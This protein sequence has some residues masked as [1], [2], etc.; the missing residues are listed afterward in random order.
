LAS[1][2][3]S[4]S[5][6]TLAPLPPADSEIGR[7]RIDFE[8]RML[9][10]LGMY[11]RADSLLAL[12]APLADD[13]R[14]V[15]Y[16]IR[17][18]TLNLMAG[19]YRQVLD[20]LAITDSISNPTFTAYL[21]Y[22]RLKA[23][24]GLER[25]PE[26]IAA[27]ERLLKIDTPVSLT[28]ESELALVEAYSMAGRP[29]DALELATD[30]SRQLNRT[31]NKI[32]LLGLRYE[33]LWQ[34]DDEDRAR[35]T[36]VK[37]AR[38]YQRSKTAQAVS[39]DVIGN[40]D[41]ARLKPDELLAH[42]AV[43]IEHGNF[44]AA[45]RLLKTL[46]QRKLNGNQ[47][48]ERLIIKARYH[49]RSGN[50]RMAAA[51]AKPRFSTPAYRR[52]SIL[53]LARSYRR[54]GKRAEAAD[55]Y[56]YF[57]ELYPNDGK[58]AEALHVAV[59]LYESTGQITKAKETLDRLR[60]SY[61]SSYYGRMATYK[62]A[63]RFNETGEYN[64]SVSVLKRA[65]SRS[66]RTDD[67][68]LFYLADTY[69][70]MGSGSS[71]Q[72]LSHE[73]QVLNPYSF[74]L[75]PRIEP[76]FRR[77]LTTST[78]KVALDGEYGLLV[79]LTTVTERKEAARITVGEAVAAENDPIAMDEAVKECLQRGEW[80]LDVGF[81][82]WGERELDAARRRCLDSPMAL[83]D[84]GDIYDRYGMPWQSI[85][86]YQRVKDSINWKQRQQYASEF[87]FLMYP[88][89]YPVQVLENAA[90]CDL[91]PH[92]VYAMIREESRFDRQ[93]V[94]RVGALGLMQLMPDTARRVAREL[95]MPGWTEESLLDPE[96]NLAF[97]I[98]YAASLA[99]AL[100]GD[101]LKM[102]AG[103]NAGPANAKRWFNGST[104]RSTIETV[105]GIDYKETRLYVQRIVES[106]NV[107]H[108]LYF[109][110]DQ[111][112]FGSGH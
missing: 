21:E 82:D 10:E 112:G 74:Y 22:L 31:R 68:A 72:L 60:K 39:L 36:A 6:Y 65:V 105:D 5:A 54:M 8:V 35:S 15:R 80:F 83:L 29:E 87:R 37:L 28:P 53:I 64:R 79:F 55:L 2:G 45:K 78:G 103:Y 90:R 81:R 99:E 14:I 50:Y 17:R 51:L 100:G 26:A 63:Q 89:P 101:Y 96:V 48:E 61:P 71:Y 84:L 92:L 70:K 34:T 97:G 42:A 88:V 3:E 49:Y 1:F 38:S 52:E 98:W 41:R 23:N 77:P 47:R 24:V 46:D 102:L 69:R 9:T 11:E 7:A 57:S 85:R 43:L 111:S 107:Y 76:S 58:T 33:L 19:R 20:C 25:A 86:L 62:S 106:A 13:G 110:A 16:A 95:E 12:T 67:A 91:P 109:D 56:R 94:S 40:V 66:R 4:R 104:K 75:A 73:L 32:A 27:G 93:A 108:S 18:G 44:S 30:L 59:I